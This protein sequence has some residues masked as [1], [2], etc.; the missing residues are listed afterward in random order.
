ML[1]PQICVWHVYPEPALLQRRA[2]QA[3]ARL[4]EE[5]IAARG[6]FRVVL[7]GGTT[8]RSIYE[9]L[10]G[11]EADWTAWHVYFG[12]E[13][14]LP[15]D[16]AERNSVMAWRAWLGAVGIPP[17]QIH[18]IPAE[19]GAEEAAWRYASSIESVDTFDLVLL[20]LGPDGHTA[21]LFPGQSLGVESGG[22]S[23]LA[24]HH[25][26]KPPSDRVSLSAWRLAKARRVWFV[27]T[28]PD[29]AGAVRAWRD[30]EN[31]PA[32]AIACEGGVDVWV[33]VAALV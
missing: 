18:A 2:A 29:K 30:G 32:A 9:H 17:D 12:D 1:T 11:I 33:D 19:L 24:V 25:A 15:G 27:V 3:I 4:A 16:H 7:A 31:I 14:C 8:P 28:G 26:P 5:A 10:R 23:V 13:R 22:A 20:G 6:E 21:S